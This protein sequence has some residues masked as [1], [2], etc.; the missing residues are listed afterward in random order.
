MLKVKLY[1]AQ[2]PKDRKS[3]DLAPEQMTGSECIVGR[4]STCGIVLNSP[5]VSRMHGKIELKNGQ[6]YFTDLASKDGSRLNNQTMLANQPSVL[7]VGDILRIADFILEIEAIAF[8]SEEDVTI[9]DP[10]R[11]ILAPP[12]PE[13]LTPKQYMPVALVDPTQISRWTKGELAVKCVRIID[14]THDAK[15]FSFVTDPPTLFSYKPGQFVT[16]DLDIDGEQVLRSYSISSTPSRPHTL[17]ITVKRV[18]APEKEPN[19]PRGLVSNWLHD[20]LT[21]GSEIKLSGPLGKFTCFANPSQ[22]LLFISAGSGITPMMSMSRWV[23]DTVSDCNIVFLHSARSK[24]DII[25][26]HELELMAARQPNFHLAITTTRNEV[27]QSWSGLRGRI[28]ESML[29]MVAADFRDRTVYVC[30]PDSF[31]QGTKALLESIGFPMQNYYEESFGGAKKSKKAAPEPTPVEKPVEMPKATVPKAFGIGAFLENLQP[32]LA[33][34]VNAPMLAATPAA[35][36]VAPPASK[37]AVVFAKADKEVACDGEESILEIAEQAGVK[38]RSSCRVGSCGTC[39]KLK[40][41]GTVKME[42]FD[43][44]ALEPS[45]QEAGFILTC[46]AFPRDRVVM[47]V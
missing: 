18:P 35:V 8:V 13:P 10:S 41:E 26:H 37:I 19:V 2:T 9:I 31:M 24:Q 15:T 25:F 17:E 7:K 44:E 14:E 28:T 32:M 36:A 45:E 43:P 23:Y 1:N 16:L 3:L 39:K 5:E 22:K 34:V 11:T 40:K 6:Y 38:I 12:L 42:D 30:G 29:Q 27:G 21:V 4:S 33:P 47:D 46:I 20:H